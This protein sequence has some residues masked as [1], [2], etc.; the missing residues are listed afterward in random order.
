M[1]TQ[2][3]SRSRN[4]FLARQALD[5]V[6]RKKLGQEP[7]SLSDHGGQAN[8]QRAGRQLADKERNDGA[9]RNKADTE[10]EGGIVQQTKAEI[11]AVVSFHL[12]GDF[13]V[14]AGRHR[15]AGLQQDAGCA[16]QPGTPG[17]EL[18][19]WAATR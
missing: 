8:G 2:T 13:V 12:G 18:T 16:M 11:P 3:G 19:H 7:A 1:R 4:R 5:H 10:P 6:G 9:G 14:G 15:L 17:T